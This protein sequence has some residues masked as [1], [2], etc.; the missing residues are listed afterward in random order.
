MPEVRVQEGD[1]QGPDPNSPEA[2]RPQG[3]RP[4]PTLPSCAGRVESLEPG[5]GKA[6]G[7]YLC[8]HDC[9]LCRGPGVVGVT[10]E[11]LGAHDIIGTT[12]GLEQSQM[13]NVS[14]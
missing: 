14:A 12:V 10:T 3:P 11:V 13:L 4:F 7:S 2:W 1:C 9:N 5:E 8:S 6:G